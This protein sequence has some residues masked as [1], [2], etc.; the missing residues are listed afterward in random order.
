M[1]KQTALPGVRRLNVNTHT[2][3]HTQSITSKLIM[4]LVKRVP[5]HMIRLGL[6]DVQSLN[7]DT[8]MVKHNYV[9]KPYENAWTRMAQGEW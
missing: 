8:G 9:S 2:H 4:C 7:L 6:E 5:G 1:Q 3:T